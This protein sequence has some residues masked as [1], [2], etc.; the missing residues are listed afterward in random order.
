[1]NIFDLF[2]RSG[3]GAH[4][5]DGL[6]AGAAARPGAARARPPPDRRRARH[7]A[8]RDP[9]AGPRGRVRAPPGA[10][11]RL[12][13]RHGSRLGRRRGSPAV[14]HADSSASAASALREY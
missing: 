6:A 8:P 5:V 3:N 9:V 12:R 10:R 2:D 1:M 11:S 7:S 14:G 4:G 13:R